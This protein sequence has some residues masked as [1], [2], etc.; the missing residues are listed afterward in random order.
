MQISTL[1]LLAALTVPEY[2]F[3]ATASPSP[4]PGTP[5]AGPGAG[6]PTTSPTSRAERAAPG[7]GTPDRSGDSRMGDSGPTSAPAPGASMSQPTSVRAGPVSS[8]LGSASFQ[9]IDRNRD[10]FLSTDE[11]RSSTVG[12][13][14]TELDTDRDGR[15]SAEELTNNGR[16]VPATR[17]SPSAPAPVAR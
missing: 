17:A 13:R 3:E 4:G 10:G 11:L 1:A 7:T 5:G 2:A 14:F 9:G 16:T 15:I 8:E 12:S 6:A